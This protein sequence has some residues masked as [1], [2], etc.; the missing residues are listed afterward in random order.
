[1]RQRFF[2]HI[3]RPHGRL[4]FA[5]MCFPQEKHTDTGLTDT[6]ADGQRQFIMQDRFLERKLCPF[7]TARFFELAAQ[8]ILIHTDTHGG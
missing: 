2:Y 1:M 3:I 4:Y 5:D 7:G 6:A 8:G